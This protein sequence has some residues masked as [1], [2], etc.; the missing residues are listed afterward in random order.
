MSMKEEARAGDPDVYPVKSSSIVFPA[1]ATILYPAVIYFGRMYMENKKPFEIRHWVFMYNVYQCVLNAWTVIEMIREFVSNPWYRCIYTVLPWGNKVQP[2]YAGFRMSWLV[3]LH[4]N[5]K[6]V[7]LLD[8]VWMVLRKKNNQ[9]TLLHCYHHILLIWVWWHCCSVESGGEAW[10]GACV[11]SLIH[12]YMYG[13]YTMSLLK[14]RVEWMK[15]YMTSC[16]LLQFVICLVHA[17]YVYYQTTYGA[18]LRGY[19]PWEMCADQAFVMVNMLGLFG[20]FFYKSY[21]KQRSDG[22]TKTD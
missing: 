18:E 3:W 8:T 4:Y 19:I 6:F 12:V 16:Q 21:I 17:S 10:F 22:R 5:N 15:I 14:W 1:V 20:H 2:G 9:I 13:Y 11:N 7:E